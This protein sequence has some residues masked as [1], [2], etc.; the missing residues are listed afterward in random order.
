MKEETCTKIVY[1]E[2]SCLL[3]RGYNNYRTEIKKRCIWENTKYN[4]LLIK[5]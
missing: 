4:E 3:K 1:C 5:K 2:K